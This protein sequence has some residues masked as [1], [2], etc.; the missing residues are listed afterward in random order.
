MDNPIQTDIGTE[1]KILLAARK[2]FFQKG[3][4]GARMQDIANEA[5]IN[6]AI[7]HYYFRSKDQLF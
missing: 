5:G 7:L 2:I 6:K 3:L 1:Q 4:A